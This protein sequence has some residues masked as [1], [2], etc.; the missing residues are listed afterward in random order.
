M[1]KKE[2]LVLERQ[3]HKAIYKLAS[4]QIV[5]RLDIIETSKKFLNNICFSC[6]ANGNH[7]ADI[8]QEI[9]VMEKYRVNRA[10][11]YLKRSDAASKWVDSDE[12][13][14]CIDC[15]KRIPFKRIRLVPISLRCVQCEEEKEKT[16]NRFRSYRSKSAS[17][18]FL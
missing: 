2:R 5:L 6:P 14:N 13:G 12:F 4:L 1:S 17:A 9:P 15:G 10:I 8:E 3:R 18:M 7:P 11:E 16:E